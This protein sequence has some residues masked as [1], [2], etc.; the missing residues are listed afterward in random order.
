MFLFIFYIFVLVNL[1]IYILRRMSELKNQVFEQYLLNELKQGNENAFATLFKIWYKDL[2]LFAGSFISNKEKCEDIVQTLFLKLWENRCS[3]IINTSLKSYL[4]KSVRNY[5]I[6]YYKHESIK[7]TYEELYNLKHFMSDDYESYI[8]YSD[9]SDHLEKVLQEL[10]PAVRETFE[11]SRFAGMKYKEIANQL[12]VSERCVEARI[13][14]ATLILRTELKEF[15]PIL[16]LIVK[17]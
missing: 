8:L 6:D 15:L 2:V 1:Y 4:L 17:L 10:D 14:K 11:M 12:N 9:L 5:C 7:R 3:L 13:S 16:L